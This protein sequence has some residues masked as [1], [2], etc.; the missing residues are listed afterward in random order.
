MAF[1]NLKV[2][3]IVNFRGQL[4]WA[5]RSPD[6]GVLV[7]VFGDEIRRQWVAESRSQCSLKWVGLKGSGRTEKPQIRVR[8]TPA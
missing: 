8:V 5:T 2:K 3:M 6:T 1:P 7:C 4:D